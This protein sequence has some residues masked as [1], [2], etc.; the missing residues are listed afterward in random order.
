MDSS[1][2][3]GHMEHSHCI[4]LPRPPVVAPGNDTAYTA[5]QNPARCSSKRE[6]TGGELVGGQATSKPSP[7]TPTPS[8]ALCSAECEALDDGAGH[9][10]NSG[11]PTAEVN[12][13]T[14]ALITHEEFLAAF[15]M[16]WNSTHSIPTTSLLHAILH[17]SQ[18]SL[19]HLWARQCPHLWHKQ[20]NQAPLN[21]LPS[22]PAKLARPSK[23]GS[24]DP[25]WFNQY[26]TLRTPNG[27]WQ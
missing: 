19:G 3:D 25:K 17:D 27:D 13:D 18:P 21:E 16:M 8:P 15:P 12:S 9:G 22:P 24:M 7:K 23:A 14:S 1:S 20:K 11:V 6:A 4:Q 26:S 5:F 2:S 10:G